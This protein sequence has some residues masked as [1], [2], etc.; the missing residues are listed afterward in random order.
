MTTE[1]TFWTASNCSAKK[2]QLSFVL[3]YVP[4]LTVLDVI[5]IL[6]Q[7]KSNLVPQMGDKLSLK[8]RAIAFEIK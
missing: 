4:L 5:T 8:L 2:N 1:I 6:E 7:K 3:L